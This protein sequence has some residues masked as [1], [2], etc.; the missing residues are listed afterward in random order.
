MNTFKK[1]LK[2]RKK[3]SI[4]KPTTIGYD[5]TIVTSKGEQPISIVWNSKNVQIA[6]DNISNGIKTHT[7]FHEKNP[8]RRASDV[9]FK[10]T[11][12]EMD[13]YFE[14]MMDLHHYAEGH[15]KL[16]NGDVVGNIKLRDY[17]DEQLRLFLEEP[18]KRHIML[19]S[20]QASKTTSS[21]I[22][23]LWNMTFK[24]NK[25]TAIL[26]NKLDTSKEV[27]TK[28]K[29]IYELMPFYL[30]AGVV[31][32][33]EKTV[34][35]DNKCVIL[36]RPCTKDSLNGL[37]VFILY[38]DE[39]AFCF[40]GDKKQ[41][42][43]FLSQAQPTL[44]S[45]G[46]DAILII[47]S[48]PNGK[49]YFYELFN[50]AVK[51][52]NSYTPT[53]VYWWQIPDR[54]Q[55][56]AD[57]WKSDIGEEKF[58]IQF[59]LSF[60]ATMYKLLEPATMLRLGKASSKFIDARE[61]FD[62][63]FLENFLQPSDDSGTECAFRVSKNVID[64]ETVDNKKDFFIST[65]DL[66]EGLGGESDD[67]TAHVFKICHKN[68][69]DVPH[70]YFRQEMVYQSN[71]YGLD[72][73]SKFMCHLHCDVLDQ[74][75]SRYLFEANKYGDL[76]RQQIL[77]IGDE[78]FDRELYAETFFKFRRSAD[79]NRMSIGLLTNRAIKPLA[80]KSFKKA[81]ENGLYEV[82]DDKTIEQIK[83]FQKDDK[84]NFKAELGH[85]DLVTPLINMSW[86]VALNPIALREVVEEYLDFNKID[87]NNFKYMIDLKDKNNKYM[88]NMSN[89]V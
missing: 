72:N 20:R 65:S 6:K 45:A 67:T 22:F 69:K 59:E 46:K 28:I 33:N 38:I 53:K 58:K 2:T 5:P 87:I 50:R 55:A 7:P 12:A 47:T 62:N 43:E 11:K 70:I 73:F 89:E 57:T 35:F 78:D 29:E 68:I 49:D 24:N 56:W 36:A 27:L 64:G 13:E 79:S 19:W 52:L 39:F 71:I 23:I 16:K 75:K 74:E 37:S 51:G 30:Q 41:Q 17:Q 40:D 81:M 84:G 15:C 63:E 66:A 8:S 44:S 10:P 86:L 34:A 18:N 25:L 88:E 4:K 32:W 54:D 77:N 21:C 9:V 60:D 82:T 61:R 14:C 26:G 3:K 1:P 80:V 83:N 42:S 85:D 48:T 76:H 31:G